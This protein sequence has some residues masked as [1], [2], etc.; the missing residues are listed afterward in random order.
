MTHARACTWE[1]EADG[2]YKALADHEA[3][4]LLHVAAHKTAALATAS[5][6][7]QKLRVKLVQGLAKKQAALAE[8]EKKALKRAGLT[9]Q[10]QARH[11]ARCGVV[12]CGV[13][14]D[15]TDTWHQ[16]VACPGTARRPDGPSAAI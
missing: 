12:W 8:H 4:M 16:L 15:V 9:A 2:R 5:E 1:Q 10:E 7:E 3:T 14:C 13:T 6:H 11:L